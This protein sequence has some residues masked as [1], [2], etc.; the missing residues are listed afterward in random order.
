[1]GMFGIWLLAAL[2]LSPGQVWGSAP[3]RAALVPQGMVAPA[4]SLLPLPSPNKP[5]TPILLTAECSY[6]VKGRQ[7]TAR[8]ESY[9]VVRSQLPLRG[10]V[11]SQT[12]VRRY[13]NGS[14][15]SSTT[16]APADLLGVPPSAPDWV[17]AVQCR[18][19]RSTD[20]ESGE[21]QTW[22]DPAAAGVE[23]RLPWPGTPYPVSGRLTN[24]GRVCVGGTL[25]G[26]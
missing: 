18:G 6:T 16:H 10:P 14:L 12:F 13:R 5:G 4:P 23:V 9:V 24:D 8:A 15:L 2:S 17:A 19:D 26:L 3:E 25:W 20:A 21:W 1:M 22:I 11:S 7:W